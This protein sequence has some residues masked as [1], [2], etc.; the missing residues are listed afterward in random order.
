MIKIFRPLLK[1]VIGHYIT[2]PRVSL[3]ANLRVYG[4]ISAMSEYP[5][6]HDGIAESQDAEPESRASRKIDSETSHI[7]KCVK[8]IIVQVISDFERCFTRKFTENIEILKNL[9]HHYLINSIV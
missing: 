2:L 3:I 5:E 7:S 9:S 1:Y 4:S 6:C 8:S